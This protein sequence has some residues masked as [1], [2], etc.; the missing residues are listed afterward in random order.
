MYA[1]IMRATNDMI[2]KLDNNAH[3][4]AMRAQWHILHTRYFDIN[5]F[6]SF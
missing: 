4:S 3:A 1:L 2:L 5:S 6:S